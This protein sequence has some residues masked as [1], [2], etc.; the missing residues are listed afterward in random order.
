MPKLKQKESQL[1][2]RGARR[3]EAICYRV[4]GRTPPTNLSIY[5]SVTAV[6]FLIGRT[7]EKK[8]FSR[9]PVK[10]LKSYLKATFEKKGA[11]MGQKGLVFKICS[12]HMNCIMSYMSRKIGGK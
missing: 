8:L 11:K 1:A 12:W 7:P 4:F 9:A 5:V 10:L 3:L 2:S 6:L